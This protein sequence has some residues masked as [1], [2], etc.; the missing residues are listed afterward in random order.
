MLEFVEGVNILHGLNGVGKT[1]VIEAISLCGF[2]KSFLPTQDS[3]LVTNGAEGYSVSA[4]CESD[5]QIP[6]KVSVSFFGRKSIK[7]SHGDSLTPK[8]IIGEIPM[9]IL[10]PDFK[11][12]TFGAPS[13]RRAFLDR[14]LSQCSRRYYE[15]LNN[16]R[17]ILKQRNN[18]LSSKSGYFDKSLLD[19]WTEQLIQCS[20]EIISR[21]NAFINEFTPYFRTAYAHISADGE[22]VSVHYEPNGVLSFSESHTQAEIYNALVKTARD[23]EEDEKRRGLTLFG[24]QKDEVMIMINNG[25]A[26][27]YASQGQHKSLLIAIKSAEFEYLKAIRH[28]TPVLLLDD[29]FSELDIHRTERV[30]ETI[31]THAK[32]TFITTTEGGRLNSF[33]PD[34][35]ATK[36]FTVVQGIVVED[37][38][39]Q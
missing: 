39:L 17:K 21:R 27:D 36:Y 8:D 2:S 12:I 23:L 26:R 18:L 4:F 33:I 14:L 15:E 22:K 6:Y 1:T 16:L 24:P 29:V 9:V 7:S 20:C 31:I 10:S 3:F 28:E 25:V 38:L 11:M 34:S 30:F 35:T 32:Q 5:L 13:D 37:S 19:V